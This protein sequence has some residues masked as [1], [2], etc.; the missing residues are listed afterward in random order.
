MSLE[1][2]IWNC[3]NL[4][5]KLLIV[6]FMV[7]RV[8]NLFGEIDKGLI[9]G[10]VFDILGVVVVVLVVLIVVFLVFC[11]VWISFLEIKV[12]IFLKKFEIDG[13]DWILFIIFN[14]IGNFVVYYFLYFFFWMRIRSVEI[15]IVNVINC[16]FEVLEVL[17]RWIII[18]FVFGRWVISFLFFLDGFVFRC[19]VV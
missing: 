7:E 17:E 13:V 4:V 18:F 1:F 9:D 5:F 6:F 15:K 14:R 19:V 16:F 8:F 11:E 10:G 2:I 3:V 12:I